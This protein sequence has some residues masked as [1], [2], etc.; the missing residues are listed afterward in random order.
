MESRTKTCLYAAFYPRACKFESLHTA[1]SSLFRSP[2]VPRESEQAQCASSAHENGWNCKSLDECGTVK[3]MPSTKILPHVALQLS[4]ES[5]DS[6]IGRLLLIRN[7]VVGSSTLA[8][9]RQTFHV[10]TYAGS[11][12]SGT[13]TRTLGWVWTVSGREE[14]CIV[15][16][17]AGVTR[18]TDYWGVE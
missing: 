14:Q 13:H 10:L 11:D 6:A 18:M 4:Q 17:S 15:L 7:V 8:F 1:S 3:H 5:Q 12:I 9:S 2:A 16:L